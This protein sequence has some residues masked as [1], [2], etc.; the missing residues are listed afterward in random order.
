[1]GCDVVN[2]YVGDAKQPVAIHKGLLAHYAPAIYNMANSVKDLV[3]PDVLPTV[4][5]FFVECL[6]SRRVPDVTH[7]MKNLA[8][9]FRLKYLIHLY[10]FT[11]RYHMKFEL[12]NMIMDR[13]QDGFLLMNMCP[14][15]DF[16]ATIYANTT[17]GS[18]SGPHFV[19]MLPNCNISEI[20]YNREP[21]LMYE[22][23]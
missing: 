5:K 13:I 23:P 8:Q 18:V 21:E 11:D 2:I 1:M 6:Y 22:L 7:D 4:F 3:L 12:K 20:Y 16:I 10:A 19:F 14:D 9:G 17:P 15:P